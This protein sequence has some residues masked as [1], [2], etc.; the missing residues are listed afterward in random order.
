MRRTAIPG[1]IIV[2]ATGAILGAGQTPVPERGGG[3]PATPRVPGE[4]LLPLDERTRTFRIVEG[5]RAGERVTL[6]LRRAA[7]NEVGDW[8]LTMTDLNVMH[9]RR[10]RAGA[11]EVLRLELPRENRAIDYQPAVRL[12]PASVVPQA[13]VEVTGIARISNLETGEQVRSGRFSHQVDQVTR[14]RF[15]TQAGERVGYLVVV[16]HQVDLDLGQLQL[17]LEGGFV[18]GQGMVYRHMRY[19]IDKLFVFSETTRRTAVLAED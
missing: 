12:I 3:E 11:V 18:P 4:Q 16:D 15:N 10:T 9:L 8:V 6:T 17:S 2:I 5:D 1:I 19:T 14:S 13:R 7:E